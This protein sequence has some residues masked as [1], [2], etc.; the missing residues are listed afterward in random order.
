MVKVTRGQVARGQIMEIKSKLPGKSRKIGQNTGVE[1]G[2]LET[3][4]SQE[5]SGV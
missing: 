1:N 5:A 2:S 3:L 4:F